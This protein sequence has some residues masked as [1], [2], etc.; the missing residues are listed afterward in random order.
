MEKILVAFATDNGKEF[1]SRHFGDANFYD[2]YAINEHSADFVKRIENVVGEEE[3]HADPKKSKGI[4]ELLEK[5]NVKVV[6]SKIFGPNILKIKKKF[7]CILM[8]DES[9]DESMDRLCKNIRLVMEEWGKGE[10]RKHL[11]L[12]K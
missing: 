10:D 12:R 9:L 7:V 1:M 2:I 3:I 5:E 6:V 11:V 8:N 4:T